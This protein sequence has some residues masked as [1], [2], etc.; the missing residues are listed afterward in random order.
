MTSSEPPVRLGLVGCGGISHVHAKAALT[1]PET[2]RIAA[3]CDIHEP[4]AKAWAEKYGCESHHAD[5]A[6]MLR[7]ERLD[8]VLL[9]TWPNQHREQIERCLDAGARA[10]LCE[11]ALAL[12]P[13][14]ALEIRALARARAAIVMEG[15]MFRHHPAVAKLDELLASGRLGPLDSIRADFSA[16]DAERAPADDA[17]RNWRQRKEC[18]GGIPFDFACYCVNACQHF[19]GAPPVRVWC[20]GGTSPHYGT[21]NRMYAMLEYANGVVATLESSKKA[22]HSQRV[23]LACAHGRLVLPVAWSLPLPVA[24][25][26]QRCPGWIDFERLS[27]PVEDANAYARQFEN[28]AAAIRGRARPGMPLDESVANAYTLEALIAS[29]EQGEPVAVKLPHDLAAALERPA[30]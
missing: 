13:A 25:A 10:I 18:G 4:A 16:Y 14:E 29:L 11:K 5:Y 2:V 8:G 24:I 3:C 21:V 17:S 30:R 6:A 15:F 20:R 23:E 9:A 27:H 12:S 26:E 19:A 7:A 22:N 28:F 1:I